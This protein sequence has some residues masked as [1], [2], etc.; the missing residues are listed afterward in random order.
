MSTRGNLYLRKL[1]VHGARDTLRWIDT[2]DDERSR[3]L[4][5]LIAR[6]R[7]NRAAVALANK[8]A[9]IVWALLTVL[10]QKSTSAI[11]DGCNPLKYRDTILAKSVKNWFLQQNPPRCSSR[12]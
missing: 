3:W 9:R 7:K 10:L 12:R 11:F 5:A 2:K 6:R 1:F 4:K 8:N